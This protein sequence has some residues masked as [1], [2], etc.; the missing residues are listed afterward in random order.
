MVKQAP[1]SKPAGLMWQ[2]SEIAHDKFSN[3]VHFPRLWQFIVTTIIPHKNLLKST[4][5]LQKTIN[6]RIIS[7]WVFWV[8]NIWVYRKEYVRS[9]PRSDLSH[10]CVHLLVS[11]SSQQSRLNSLHTISLYC[12]ASTVAGRDQLGGMQGIKVPGRVAVL[13]ND[14]LKEMLKSFWVLY[15]PVV[16]SLCF[17]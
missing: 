4:P 9:A 14:A 11:T 3:F 13:L 8:K 16:W 10:G 6:L 12:M 15:L 17:H 2:D 5:W 7:S 1:C